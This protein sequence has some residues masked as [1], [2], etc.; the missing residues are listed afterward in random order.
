MKYRFKLVS[1]FAFI[2]FVQLA[3]VPYMAIA[4]ST[5][6]T[7]VVN[8][9]TKFNND[10]GEIYLHISNTSK[11][12]LEHDIKIY[13]DALTDYPFTIAEMQNTPFPFENRRSND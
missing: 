5:A 2:L 8:S 11:E 7:Q 10:V 13:D 1:I 4:A 6:L 3:L 12:Q 9:L